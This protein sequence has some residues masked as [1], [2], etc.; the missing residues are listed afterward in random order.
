MHDV[1]RSNKSIPFGD[2]RAWFWT[3]YEDKRDIMSDCVRPQWGVANC[4]KNHMVTVCEGRSNVDE[5]WRIVCT[6]DEGNGLYRMMV[7]MDNNGYG[8]NEV[9]KWL[10]ENG[11]NI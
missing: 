7:K 6:K 10:R 11:A 3:L 2:Y 9:N 5:V 4:N 1:W 8:R